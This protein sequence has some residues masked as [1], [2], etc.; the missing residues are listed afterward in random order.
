MRKTIAKSTPAAARC[1]KRRKTMGEHCVPN[2]P[3]CFLRAS[4]SEGPNMD[5]DTSKT[6][7]RGSG[8]AV[9][10]FSEYTSANFVGT[11]G[12]RQVRSGTRGRNSVSG[13]TGLAQACDQDPITPFVQA[14]VVQTTDLAVPITE[15]VSRSSTYANTPGFEMK[16]VQALN[17]QKLNTPLVSTPDNPSVMEVFSLP[18]VLSHRNAAVS[19][20]DGHG[21]NNSEF[22]SP[23]DGIQK[24]AL[25][26]GVHRSIIAPSSS[27]VTDDPREAGCMGENLVPRTPAGFNTAARLDVSNITSP[28]D[29]LSGQSRHAGRD[30]RVLSTEAQPS[31]SNTLA[32]KEPKARKTVNSGRKFRSGSKKVKD[33]PKLITPLEYAQKLQ[34]CLD[35]HAKLKTNY[36]KGKRIFYVGGDMMYASTTTRGRME[37]VSHLYIISS[38]CH[39]R[40]RCSAIHYMSVIRECGVA[41][42][43]LPSLYRSFEVDLGIAS[44]MYS[45]SFPQIVKH[46]GTLIPRYDPAIVT[47]I[48]TDAGVRHTLR[49]LSLK[50]LSDIPDNIPTVTWDWVVSGYGRTSK[51]KP[52]LSLDRSDKGKGV[53]EGD[54]GDDDDAFDFEFMHAAFSERIDAG[55]R[56]KNIRRGKQGGK[57][58]HDRG[59]DSA[60][61]HSG[62]ISH[63]SY[64]PAC[65]KSGVRRLPFITVLFPRRV[66]LLNTR[67][68]GFLS[69]CYHH[70]HFLSNLLEGAK[71]VGMQLRRK[72]RRH[73]KMKIPFQSTMLKRG[74]IMK[75]RLVESSVIRTV[76]LHTIVQ[77]DRDAS[78]S[79]DEGNEFDYHGGPAPRRVS[80]LSS[81]KDRPVL[82]VI[83]YSSRVL[84]VTSNGRNRRSA[85]TNISSTRQCFWHFLCMSSD[86]Q[87]VGRT[88][89]TSQSE[90]I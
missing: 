5:L 33:K 12:S 31:S 56:W 10:H 67:G 72:Q 53:A 43:R 81:V 50:S 69:P 65:E 37:Y 19:T 86:Y 73:R 25:T 39:L 17:G 29:T 57:A 22:L 62:D 83:L 14:Q 71:T 18:P 80:Q 68:A 48:V 34:S 27:M 59:R 41:W 28:G 38:H 47:H 2:P 6:T 9:Q 88:Q 8:A 63:I 42:R 77:W 52:E 78:D 23:A 21:R 75:P 61:D 36:L 35:L 70:H 3:N 76:R 87:A 40:P 85:L 32:P 30:S 79:D 11:K 15:D 45:A 84:H 90:I 4:V 54:H 66:S 46:G 74:L 44:D 16:M 55:C 24:V 13:S 7:A 58:A 49:A 82:F 26:A 64:V 51:Q 60:H 89:G 1:A 20:F